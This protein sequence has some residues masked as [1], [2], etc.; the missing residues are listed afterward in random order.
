LSRQPFT[1]SDDQASR[2]LAALR[3][4]AE[5]HPVDVRS[6]RPF[7]RD[8]IRTVHSVTGRTFSPAIYRRLLSAYAPDRHPSTTTLSIEKEFVEQ[9]LAD[10]GQT[11][12]GRPPVSTA[13]APAPPGY[14]WMPT[15]NEL[16]ALVKASVD[17]ALAR[18]G[19]FG[20]S[21]RDSEQQMAQAH[22][23]DLSAR[24]A[25]SERALAGVRSQAASL[26]ADLQVARENEARYIEQLAHAEKAAE[27]RAE[28]HLKALQNVAVEMAEIRK[29]AMRS[30]DDIR[31]ETRAERDRRVHVE[32]LL[33][34]NQK[35]MEVFRQMAYQRGGSIPPDLQIDPK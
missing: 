2:L 22:I 31:G 32:V 34:Q 3:P 12:P 17:E 33:K 15:S 18:Q 29:F 7:V 24:L 11:P 6:N 5:Q 13:A 25:A 8:F 23:A 4:V 27:I 20:A 9:E 26:A 21:R 30:I 35:M 1:L 14:S 28:T 16:S 19:N 10:A